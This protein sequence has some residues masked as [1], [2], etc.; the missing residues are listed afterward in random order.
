[1][2]TRYEMPQMAAERLTIGE[3]AEYLG[4]TIRTLRFYEQKG[5]I[6]PHRRGGWSRLYSA[7][8]LER[9][10]LILR[11]RAIGVAL[12]DIA[13]LVNA[14]PETSVPAVGDIIRRRLDDIDVTSRELAEQA[15]EARA[16]LETLAPPDEP[17][18]D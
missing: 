14:M 6:R 3:A 2:L 7:A 4:V 12:G 10:R 8:D 15:A 1:M 13:P 9:M 17:T 18:R 11:L 5:L 16:W